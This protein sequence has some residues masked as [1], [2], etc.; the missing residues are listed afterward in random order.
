MNLGKTDKYA[1]M[2][3]G[4]IV[5][6]AGIAFQSWWGIAGLVLLIT[7]FIDWCPLYALFGINTALP[8]RKK[9]HGN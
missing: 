5:L 3:I 2:L 7:A 8:K 9:H 6:L 4:I 1:R